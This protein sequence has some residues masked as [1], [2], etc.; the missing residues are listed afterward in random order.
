MAGYNGILNK[1]IFNPIG[2]PHTWPFCLALMEWIGELANFYYG[3]Q[4]SKRER[5]FNDDINAHFI[6]SY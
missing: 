2:A 3:Y 5:P 6:E 4:S 1:K